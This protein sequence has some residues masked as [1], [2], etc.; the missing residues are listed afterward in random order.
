[1]R[2]RERERERGREGGGGG[3]GRERELCKQ[4]WLLHR[5]LMTHTGVCCTLVHTRLAEESDFKQFGLVSD[6]DT[7]EPCA[8]TGVLA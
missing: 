6:L 8:T 4:E 5:V 7:Q 3:G 1:M 2:E